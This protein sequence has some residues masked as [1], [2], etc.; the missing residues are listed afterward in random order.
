[1]AHEHVE[2]KNRKACTKLLPK[3]LRQNLTCQLRISFLEREGVRKRREKR[4]KHECTIQTTE[5][6]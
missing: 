6:D 5:S 2:G 3:K 1:M 4:D